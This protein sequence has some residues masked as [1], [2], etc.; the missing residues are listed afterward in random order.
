MKIST[1][2]YLLSICSVLA[3]AQQ[4]PFNSNSGPKRILTPEFDDF[5]K[6]VIKDQ[7]IPGYSLA[8][9]RRDGGIEL[10][11]WGNMTE[12]GRPTTPD[13]NLPPQTSI[14]IY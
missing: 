8:V 9:I 13:V 14:G 7:G 12:D 11:A 4:T 5:A 3:L 1:S 10:G 6:R 2:L